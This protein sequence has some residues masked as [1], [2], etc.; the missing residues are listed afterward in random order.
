[1][2]EFFGNYGFFI[3]IALLMVGCHLGHGGHGVHGRR[4]DDEPGQDE[5][6]PRGGH[7][8]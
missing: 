8:H 4:S 6:P 5:S 2:S 3:L 1:M 7:Q